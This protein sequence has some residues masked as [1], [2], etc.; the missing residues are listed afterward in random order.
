MCCLYASLGLASAGFGAP[1][2]SHGVNNMY[3]NGYYLLY[4]EYVSG[5]T[6]DAYRYAANKLGYDNNDADFVYNMVDLGLS[7]YGLGKQVLK[8]DAWKLYQY[9]RYC[10]IFTYFLLHSDVR[11]LPS[12]LNQND[13]RM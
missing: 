8:P 13:G 7:G 11:S 1:L 5:Y 4:Q 3:E 12:R 6:K 10:V 9:I 2:I